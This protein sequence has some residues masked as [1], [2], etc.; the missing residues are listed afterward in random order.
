MDL[1]R[2][3]AAILCLNSIVVVFFNHPATVT[4]SDIVNDDDSAPKK[5]GC[6][7][8][9]VLVK[10][11]TWVDGRENAEFVGVGARF[12]TTVVSKE[13]NAIQTRLTLSDPRYCCSPPKNKF[14][15]DVVMVDRGQ[16]KFTT[17]ANVAEA[18][19]AS[20]VLIVNNQKAGSL[21]GAPEPAISQSV[22]EITKLALPGHLSNFSLLL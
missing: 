19:G 12:G 2:L 21:Y 22:E 15:G 8:D 4:A 18:A 14:S 9:F 7:N 13:K 1:R 3:C 16:C 11:Q 20:A 17:K 6:D 5:P 10:V